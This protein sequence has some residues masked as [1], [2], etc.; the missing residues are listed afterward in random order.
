M[1]VTA[2]TFLINVAINYILLAGVFWSIIYPQRRL[3]PPPGRSSWQQVVTWM[4]FVL[5]FASMAVLLVTDWNT[6]PISPEARFLVG[7]PLTL[8]GTLIVT[9]GMINLGVKNTS[10]LRH[11]LV[12]NGIYRHTRNPQYLGDILLFIGLSLVSNSIKVAVGHLC[13]SLVFLF[14]PWCEEPWLE[15]QY[16]E[17]YR[18]YAS[19]TARF[20]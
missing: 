19:R 18:N 10:G 9:W 6:G 1:E 15:E 4:L 12:C 13:M 8:L 14:T 3:W 17:A 11:G 16:G 7:I 20:L 5:G 2:V